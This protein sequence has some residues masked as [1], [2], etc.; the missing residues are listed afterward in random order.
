MQNVKKVFAFGRTAGVMAAMAAIALTGCSKKTQSA[1]MSMYAMDS[2]VNTLSARVDRL[3]QAP[4][5]TATGTSYVSKL[6]E[7]PAGMKRVYMALPS[8]SEATS[9]MLVEKLMPET[10]NAGNPFD[11][12]I[13][14]TN[15]T[16][17]LYLSNV[18]VRDRVTANLAQSSSTPQGRVSEGSMVWDLGTLAPEESKTITVTAATQG[19]GEA[20]TCAVVDY[21][22]ILCLDTLAERPQLAITYDGTRQGITC[23]TLTYTVT[24][25]NTGTGIAEDVQVNAPLPRGLTTTDGQTAISQAVGNLGPGE[26]RTITVNARAASAGNYDSRATASA[27]NVGSVESQV[28]NTAICQ[29]ALAIEASGTRMIFLNNQ[30]EFTAT[31]S[32]TSDCAV[33]NVAVTGTFPGC[34]QVLSAS[35]NGGVAGSTVVWQIGTLQPGQS[36]EVRARVLGADKCEDRVA[37]EATGECADAVDA[38][39]PV[40]IAGIPAILLE[41]IDEIDPVRV[42][43]NTVYVITATNQ[44]SAVGTNIAIIARVEELSIETVSGAT[45]GT[46]SDKTVTFAPVAALAP[47]DQATWR[48]EVKAQA[49]GDQ[50]FFVEMNS[51]QLTRPVEETEATNTYE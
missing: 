48:V 34:T 50:R 15:L 12:T 38:N 49:A 10:V 5:S 3:E 21:Q 35:D 19:V 2:E 6:G 45:A 40:E 22:P 44:G 32:N 42:G 29:P 43:E 24:V 37:F 18:V 31:V 39:V 28:V 8:G 26:S 20:A 11:Y 30:G 25:S 51:D 23:D 33:E 4:R 13:R 1:D 36:R 41:V 17:S 46:I 9:A 14:V 27:G 7:V 47:G 16:D